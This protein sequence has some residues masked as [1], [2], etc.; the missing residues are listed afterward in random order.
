MSCKRHSLSYFLWLHCSYFFQP[1]WF[2]KVV[3]MKLHETEL[4]NYLHPFLGRYEDSFR[5][6]WVD[7]LECNPWTLEEITPIIRRVR[8]KAIKQY[9]QNLSTQWFLTSEDE[10]F[11]LNFSH[12]GNLRTSKGNISPQIDSTVGHKF[13]LLRLISIRTFCHTFILHRNL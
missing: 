6:A 1:A 4:N 5:E 3:D 2:R 8:N 10:A 13:I 7:I 9:Y 12:F 11:N